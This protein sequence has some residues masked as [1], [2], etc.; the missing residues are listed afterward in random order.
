MPETGLP[1]AGPAEKNKSTASFG[2]DVDIPSVLDD[3]CSAGPTPVP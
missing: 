2:A 3:L 1:D